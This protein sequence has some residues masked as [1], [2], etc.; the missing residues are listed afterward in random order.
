MRLLNAVFFLLLAAFVQALSWTA[1]PFNPSAIPLAVRTPYLSAWLPQGEGAALNDAWATFWTG[2]IVGWAG[3]VKVDGTPYVFLGAPS[4]PSVTFSKAVQKS[5]QFTSTQSIFVLSAG[6][7][8]LTVTFL[9]PVEPNDLVKQS[10]PFSYMAVSAAA[11]DGKSHSV[12][13]YSDISAEWTSGDNS[14]TVNWN[15]TTSGSILTH[16]VQLET[17]TVFGEVNDH[18]QCA[19]VSG[20]WLALQLTVTLRRVCI[21]FHPRMS[22]AA[23]P[24]ISHILTDKQTVSATYQTGQDIVVRAQFVTNGKLTNTLDTNFRAIEDD[25]PVFGFAHDLGTVTTVSTPVVFSVGHIRDPALEYIIA[26]GALENRNLYYMSEF[27]TSAAV[28]AEFLGDYSAALTRANRFDAQVQTDASKIS[29]DY[30]AI[31]ALSIR[32]ALGAVEITLSKTS[33]GAFNTSDIIV[34]MKEISSDGNVN[35]VD[36]IF[37]AWQ[38]FGW[39]N[40][41]YLNLLS[42]RSSC[43]RTLL[44]ANTCSKASS[45]IRRLDNIRTNKWSVHD[46]GSSYPKALGHNDGADEAMPVEESGNMVIMAL[47]YAQKTGDISQLQ[48]YTTLLAQ[49]TGFLV[50]DSL[51]PANQISTDDFAGALA[52]QTN[53]AI[54]GIVGIGAMGQIE[55]LLGNTA[56]ASNYSGEHGQARKWRTMAG[57]PQWQTFAASSTGAHLTLNYG[58][59]SSWGLSYNLFGDKLLGLNLF[60]ESIYAEQTAWYST[61]A[62]AFG[63]P[64]DT[65]HTYTKT[66]WE[67]LTASW[68]TTTDV[69]DLLITAVKDWVSDGLNNGPFGDLYDT[70]SGEIAIGFRARPVVGGHLALLVV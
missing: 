40:D 15:S 41:Q 60:P 50:S 5:S 16:Q 8:D 34:F 49:W 69:R 52:N 18:T 11:T 42:G 6:P 61:H 39:G 21:L 70:I 37:P 45:V 19:W 62:N 38:V 48:Q 53:L 63:V 26:G 23:F 33:T 46:L 58:N 4:V 9:S 56:Q 28:I 10:I 59:S 55:T 64:L 47:S 51:I 3:F 20:S 29:A 32:Q 7:V 66:D 24:S 44:W 30:A 25:W 1:T 12:Q 22:V 17:Q 65:R 67:C 36:V 68:A 13:V 31:V 43:T 2:M 14:L 54:K 27:S 57:Y 35:T